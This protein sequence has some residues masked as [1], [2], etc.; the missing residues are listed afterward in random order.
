MSD[1]HSEYPVLLL[2]K[3]FRRILPNSLVNVELN[4]KF[5]KYVNHAFAGDIDDV[6]AQKNII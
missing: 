4:S 3:F 1:G 6:T 5:L 2:K